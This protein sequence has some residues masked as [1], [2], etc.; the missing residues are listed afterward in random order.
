MWAEEVPGKWKGTGKLCAVLCWSPGVWG[1]DLKTT[2]KLKDWLFQVG[3]LRREAEQ[4]L[5][6]PW[7]CRTVSFTVWRVCCVQL[8]LQGWC[9]SPGNPPNP[10]C[11]ALS[12]CRMKRSR[13]RPCQWW[14]TPLR[15]TAAFLQRA[16]VLS[17]GLALL[18]C[19]CSPRP[20]LPLQHLPKLQ[21]SGLS[22]TAC[23][24]LWFRRCNLAAFI[25]C[26]PIK[27]CSSY[28]SQCS[29]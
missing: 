1:E 25:W 4:L 19:H 27:G 24:Y 14:T 6:V 26:H 20:R 10:W 12:S 15:P 13:A 18:C 9:Q 28:S 5:R 21:G 11:V 23:W 3:M 7:C 22:H 16:Q 29:Q 8:E 17:P 2:L